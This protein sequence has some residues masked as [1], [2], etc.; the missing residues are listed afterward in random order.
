MSEI[1]IKAYAKINLSLDVLG[2]RSDGYHDLSTVM[3]TVSLCDDIT[4]S[5]RDD[6]LIKISSDSDKIPCGEND[7]T[8]KAAKAFSDATG[9]EFGADKHVEKNIPVSAGL[10]GGSADAAAVLRALCILFEKDAMADE[11]ARASLSVGSDV[12][13]CLHGGCC[14]AEGRGEILSPCRSLADCHIVIAT[15][16]VMVS[17]KWAFEQIDSNNLSEHPDTNGLISAL[18]AGNL[19]EV[20]I[21]MY[22]VFDTVSARKY[23]AIEKIK[24]K[25]IDCGALG[26]IM[27]GSGPSVFGVF[28]D[29]EKASYAAKILETETRH[30]SVSK[31]V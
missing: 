3:Q 8:Y 22:N 12:P 21:R 31:P 5:L 13:F 2:K 4:V 16:D 26:S 29:F 30:V 15:P 14:L 11:I 19:R 18:E 6:N 24:S 23:P 9:I 25:M 28:D 10:A 7:L 20:A 17:T 27:S 1:K